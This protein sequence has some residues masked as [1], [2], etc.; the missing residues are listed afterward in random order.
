M[1]LPEGDGFIS[2][3]LFILSNGNYFNALGPIKFT[4]L[5]GQHQIHMNK[6]NIKKRLLIL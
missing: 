4:Y 2:F 1:M 6:N 5:K 3:Y